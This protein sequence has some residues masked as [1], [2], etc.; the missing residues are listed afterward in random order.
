M[1]TV[2]GFTAE[3]MLE[4]ENSTVV[5]GHISGDNLILEQRDGTT[6]DAGN[7]RGPT[8]ATGPTGG[9]LTGEIRMTV[10]TAAP[11]DWFLL[12]GQTVLDAQTLY[13]T[14][15]VMAPAS[16]KSGANIILPNATR[17]HLVGGTTPG[18]VGGS[19]MVS[20]LTANLP[21]HHH[22]DGSLVDGTAGDHDHTAPDGNVFCVSIGSGTQRLAQLGEASGNLITF[23]SV[24]NAGNHTHPITGNT[25]DTPSSQ[26][27]YE[28]RP[29]Y[30]IVNLMVYMGG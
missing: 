24:D 3:R 4:I 29:Q 20:L 27:P 22:A 16:W 14:F 17:R 25:A 28:H 8:G 19:D 12:N 2:T 6:I 11:P 7:V 23:T 30:L 1:V 21:V 9:L 15:W 26:T 13:P 18:V 5:D 10:M